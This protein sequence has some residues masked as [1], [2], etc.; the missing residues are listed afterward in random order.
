MM[1]NGRTRF[2]LNPLLIFVGVIALPFGLPPA[3]GQEEK[4]VDRA[5]VR[6]TVG[7]NQTVDLN[8]R[9]KLENITIGDQEKIHVDLVQI[10]NKNEL[11]FKP[12]KPGDT[13]VMIRDESG[14]LKLIFD[15]QITA[16]NLARN[17]NEIRDLLKDVEGLEI[18]I[19]GEK[20]IVDGEVLV[21][22]DYAR[23]LSVIDNYKGQVLNLT[24]LSPIAMQLL[25][26]RIQQDIAAFAPNVST[27][28]VNGMIF[29]EGSVDN[30]AQADRAEEVAA[31]YLPAARPG[32]Q[33][34]AADPGAQVLEG[35][36]LVQNFIVINP[37]PQR[38]QE[39]LVRVTVHFVELAKGYAK[40]FGFKW[41]PTL[42]GSPSV[43][44]GQSSQGGADSSVG[45]TF[46][47]VISS[48]FPKLES[49]SNAGYARVLKTGNVITRSGQ[50]GSI[51]EK[52]SFP[53]LTIDANGQPRPQTVDVGLELKV[54]PQILGDSDDILM[55]IAITQAGVVERISGGAPVTASQNITTSLYIKSNESAAIGG[56]NMS[57]VKT[58]FNK[59]DP[60]AGGARSPASQNLFRLLNSKSYNKKK[61]Q[62]VVFVTPQIVENASEGTQD[63]K[64]NFRVKVN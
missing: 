10:G 58:D 21:P 17:A 52:T 56:I 54:S 18:R 53:F 44:I 40:A 47:A 1:M 46:S 41:Q 60:E 13:T 36:R 8:V 51:N 23:L 63:L 48:L 2:N 24:R 15:V 25:S 29:L 42:T 12:R 59:D 34:V 38:K 61:S 26:K 9:T 33:L 49:A 55:N 62:F 39:K 31:L 32:D 6:L 28:V 45:G 7:E 57:D 20:I 30:K 27:R 50:D 4:N 16:S 14:N 64:R 11:V 35:R 5:S 3:V 37:P 19:L 43:A 22:A